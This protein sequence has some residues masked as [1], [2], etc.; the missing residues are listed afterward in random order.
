MDPVY[1][2]D[3]LE[4]RFRPENLVKLSSTFAQGPR[5][6]ESISLGPF[7]I[8]T[9][10]QDG[11]ASEYRGI[12]AIVQ[13]LG[14]YFQA[15]LHFCPD[16]IERELGRAFHLYMDLLFTVN[17]THT[18]ESLRT[19]HFT[20]HRKRMALGLYDPTGWKDRDTEL[21]QSILIR[22]ELTHGN[23]AVGTKRPFGKAFIREAGGNP[24]ATDCCMNWNE[25]RCDRE[26]CRYRHACKICGGTHPATGHMGTGGQASGPNSVPVRPA[27]NLKQ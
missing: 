1:F 20:F 16:G 4:N 11:H 24:Q 25:G 12:T 17:R 5:R 6:Q 19:F 7:T 27:S 9:S 15:L 8:P 10:E 2:K 14:I 21:Q 22:R 26:T 13:P 23:L 3:I 18:I